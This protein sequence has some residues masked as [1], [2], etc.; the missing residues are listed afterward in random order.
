MPLFETMYPKNVPKVGSL[1]KSIG[2]KVVLLYKMAALG[3]IK[4]VFIKQSTT[5]S[6][7]KYRLFLQASGFKLPLKNR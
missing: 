3:S 6:E 1:P 7:Q 5:N 4:P 2:E